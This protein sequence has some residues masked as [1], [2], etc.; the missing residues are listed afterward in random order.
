MSTVGTKDRDEIALRPETGQA[1]NFHVVRDATDAGSPR[2]INAGI[3][4]EVVAEIDIVGIV[5]KPRPLAKYS[6]IGKGQGSDRLGPEF[7]DRMA[8]RNRKSKGF[9]NGFQTFDALAGPL[10]HPTC[11]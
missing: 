9:A 4:S 3:E 7:L 11:P 5:G 8:G 1:S 6:D 2:L 10:A